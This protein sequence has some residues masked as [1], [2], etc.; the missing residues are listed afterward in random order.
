MNQPCPFIYTK[1]DPW[2]SPIFFIYTKNDPWSSPIPASTQKIIHEPALSLQTHKKM[3]HE[4]ALSLHLQKNIIHETALSLRLQKKKDPWTSPIPLNTQKMI[5][6]STV[7]LSTQKWS[8][9]GMNQS[10]PFSYT[11]ND[12]WILSLPTQNVIQKQ[13]IS[14]SSLSNKT[15]NPDLFIQHTRW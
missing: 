4:P 14:V 9:I 3:I 6:E 1:N 5:Q 12:I 15:S 11:N 7:P 8:M 2:T 13:I 10:H